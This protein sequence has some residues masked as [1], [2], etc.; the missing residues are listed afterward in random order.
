MLRENMN[1]KG[2]N[3]L[4]NYSYFVVIRYNFVQYDTIDIFAAI[5][6]QT[7]SNSLTISTPLIP[8]S[9]ITHR[10]RRFLGLI[11]DDVNSAVPLSRLFAINCCLTFSNAGG[12]G[13]DRALEEQSMVGVVFTPT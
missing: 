6:K 12:R 7:H 5:I 2:Q 9:K 3:Y 8:T 13:I 4:I 1:I 10:R 11:I